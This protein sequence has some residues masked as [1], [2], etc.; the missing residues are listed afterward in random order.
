MGKN[1]RSTKPKR[2]AGSL[3][4]G[5]VHRKGSAPADPGNPFEVTARMKRPKYLVHNR[6]VSKPK[7]TKHAL[8]SLQRRQVQL[9]TTLKSS[10]KVNVLVDK[11][12]GEYDPSMS[13]SD[14]MLARLVKERTRQSRRSSKFR[15]DD[16]NDNLLTHKGKQLDPN[17][18]ETIYSDD[19][20]DYGNLEA[21]DTELH[22]GGARMKQT[23]DPYGGSSGADLAQVYGQRKTELDDLIARRKT[24][25]AE[26]M[27]AKEAQV[28]T[29]EKLDEEFA[30]LSNLLLF[31]KDQPRSTKTAIPTEEEKDMNEWNSE[32]KQMMFKPKLRATDRTKTPEEIAKDEASRLHEL[33]TRRIARMRG[34]FADNDD[35]SDISMDG[36]GKRQK[37]K[38]RIA[39]RNPDELSDS[40]DSGSEIDKLEAR[41]TP[42]GLKYVDRA[43]NIVEKDPLGG[44][45]E[46]QSGD[47]SEDDS[48]GDTQQHPLPKGAKVQGNY[49][50]A[51]QFDGREAWYD[52]EITKV[53]IL[54]DGSVRYDVEYLVRGASCPRHNFLRRV[55]FR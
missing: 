53:H 54:N 46:S 10:K 2:S 51:E 32:M 39:A 34:D 45:N 6:P 55:L 42:D 43:G 49:R 50:V 15:L 26:K 8:E 31:R 9:R 52:G 19:E 36:A 17:K 35:L 37:T 5:L 44:E 7:S 4:K 27:Q 38:R 14:Q 33:E 20:D 40:E 24:I 21:V 16:S 47:E 12:I 25:K 29:V 11:R 3:P 18:T 41:F 30:E 1:N 48:A 23:L 28:E 22:F 13:S